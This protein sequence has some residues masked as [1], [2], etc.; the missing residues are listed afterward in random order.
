MQ[1]SAEQVVEGDDAGEAAGVVA[2][3]GE[4]GAASAQDLDR[5]GDR[6]VLNQFGQRAGQAAGDQG[7]HARS[8]SG[9]RP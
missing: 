9:Q 1:Q 3:D 8:V 5:V 7:V 2:D 6:G 4:R